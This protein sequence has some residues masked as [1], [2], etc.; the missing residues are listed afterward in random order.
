MTKRDLSLKPRIEDIRDKHP[1][2]VVSFSLED[3]KGHFESNLISI[4]NQFEVAQNLLDAGKVN[5]QKYIFRSQIVFLE[6]AFDFYLHELN[7]YG[8][9]QIYSGK[10]E[11]T[12]KYNNFK[13][14][15]KQ[16]EKGLASPET[17]EWF[18]TYISEVYSRD[19][20][21]SYVAANDLMNT[22]GLNLKELLK[23]A[24]PGSTNPLVPKRDA[25]KV[26]QALYSRRNQIAHQTDRAHSD[27]S[28]ADISP[29][30]PVK[31]ALDFSSASFLFP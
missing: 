27:A 8:L 1:A 17:S 7:K 10:W 20:F 24:F 15:M 2:V 26:I 23:D 28:Q 11:K 25:K 13:I 19:S 29:L 14:P 22:I 9:S 30:R 18:S 6:S 4:R 12:E 16:L 3:I 31:E 21:T 5:E